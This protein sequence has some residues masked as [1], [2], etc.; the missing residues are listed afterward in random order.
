MHCGELVPIMSTVSEH[1]SR[2]PKP[3]ESECAHEDHQLYRLTRSTL[4]SAC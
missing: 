4:H 1:S 2:D 3:G